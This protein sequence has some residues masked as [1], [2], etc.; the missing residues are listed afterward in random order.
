MHQGFCSVCWA[1]VPLV[2]QH[3]A[4]ILFGAGASLLGIRARSLL[5]MLVGVAA[6]VFA[7]HLVD[8]AAAHVC[9]KCGAPIQNLA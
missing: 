6:G 5:G 7:G 2:K 3:T 8:E 9:G 4:K 1:F